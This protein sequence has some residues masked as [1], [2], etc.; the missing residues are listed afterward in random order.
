LLGARFSRFSDLLGRALLEDFP[1][2]WGGARVFFRLAPERL[3]GFRLAR[4]RWLLHDSGAHTRGFSDLLRRARGFPF[5]LDA[6]RGI[7]FDLSNAL[8]R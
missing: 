8:S 4:A 3:L 2:S 6:S 1:F 7:F 5:A